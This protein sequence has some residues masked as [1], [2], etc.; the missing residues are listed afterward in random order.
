[1]DNAISVVLYDLPA[2]KRKDYLSWFHERHVPKLLSECGYLWAAH[3]EIVPAGRG[4]QRLVE[5]LGRTDDPGQ[6]AGIGFAALF[7]GESTRTFFTRGSASFAESLNGET[8]EMLR[9]RFLPRTWIYTVEWGMDGPACNTRDPQGT[10]APAIQMGRFNA[11]RE[12]EEDLGAWYS[13]ERM[14]AV[15][16]T[17]GCVGGRKLLAAAGDPKHAVLYEFIS[18]EA[19]ETHFLPLEG[20]EWTKRVHKYLVHPPGSPFA[21]RRIWPPV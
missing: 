13:Q 2:E 12:C 14:P 5:G 16:R 17:P 1:M 6:S 10:P 9:L 8:Q 15:S 21:A 18:L 7:G 4:F 11:L 20:T 19:R 3:Y